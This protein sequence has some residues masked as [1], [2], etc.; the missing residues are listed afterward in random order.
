MNTTTTTTN[1]ANHGT[2]GAAVK[3]TP[4]VSEVSAS[5]TPKVPSIGPEANARRFDAAA[6]A[7]ETAIAQ[8]GVKESETRAM[9]ESMARSLVRST[10]RAEIRAELSEQLSD[11]IAVYR[12]KAKAAR[13]RF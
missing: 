6:K 3:E 9:V 4:K 7:E 11:R 13:R 1:G 8:P 5:E 2:N 12:Q 10:F